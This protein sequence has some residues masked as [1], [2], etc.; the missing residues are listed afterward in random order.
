M[1]SMIR[2]LKVNVQLTWGLLYMR[3]RALSLVVV[4][5]LAVH[6]VLQLGLFHLLLL[7]ILNVMASSGR[8]TNNPVINQSR[9]SKAAKK[10]DKFNKDFIPATEKLTM[11]NLED[12][13]RLVHEFK[14]DEEVE[15]Q[16]GDLIQGLGCTRTK[17]FIFFH[18]LELY[19]CTKTMVALGMLPKDGDFK[20]LK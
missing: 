5:R 16:I 11:Q 9:V 2:V 15:D 10:A 8:K 1:R 19:W 20:Q 17:N 7:L 13:V 6:F 14:E 4:E 12:E 3:Y 18:T